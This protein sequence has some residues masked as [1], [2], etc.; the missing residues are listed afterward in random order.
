GPGQGRAVEGGAECRGVLPGDPHVGGDV[1]GGDTALR[2]ALLVRIAAK[3]GER[4]AARLLRAAIGRRLLC[5]VIGK[6]YR[7]LRTGSSSRQRVVSS[8]QDFRM[9]R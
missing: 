4:P 8:A 3:L 9:V 2:Q 1:P 7:L 6:Y 5:G